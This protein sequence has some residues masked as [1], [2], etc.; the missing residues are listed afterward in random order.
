M[1]K[2]NLFLIALTV[3]TAIASITISAVK[4]EPTTVSHVNT[5]FSDDR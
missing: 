4:D 3:I 2:A 5:V 1:T